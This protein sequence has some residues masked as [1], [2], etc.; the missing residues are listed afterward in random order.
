MGKKTPPKITPLLK[1]EFIEALKMQLEQ[2][3]DVHIRALIKRVEQL[4][5]EE[6]YKF[7]NILVRENL[8]TKE[9]QIA[10]KRYPKDWYEKYFP[11]A[12][13]VENH[14]QNNFTLGRK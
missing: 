10:Q 6:R 13:A 3:K 5:D 4:S 12:K 7:R 8:N 2:L 9:K 1:D 11:Y 14:Y